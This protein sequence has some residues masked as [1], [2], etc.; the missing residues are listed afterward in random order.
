[1][2][3]TKYGYRIKTIHEES[4]NNLNWLFFPG[5]PGLGAKYLEDVVGSLK[6]PGSKH[7]VDFP[8][9]G[10]NMH[11]KLDLKHWR[12]GLVDLL[13]NTE[14]P[15]M[16]THSFSGMFALTTPEIEKH[17]KGLVITNTT[18]NLS[19]FDHV[20]HCAE[21]YNLPDLTPELDKYHADKSKEAYKEFWKT[22][23]HYCFTAE[24]IEKAKPMLETFDYNNDSYNY[25]IENFYGDFAIKWV[26]TIPTLTIASEKDFVCPPHA[27]TGDTRFNKSNIINKVIPDAGH[28]PWVNHMNEVQMCFDEYLSK[29]EGLL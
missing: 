7:I 29:F 6:L 9:D 3:H 15:I 16:V 13:Q 24:E 22:Y 4:T 25:I 18:I 19:F 5:G 1:M 2:K 26:P 8:M 27:F 12:D 17:L 21:K 28:C 23:I 11:G 10:A 20:K 14:N